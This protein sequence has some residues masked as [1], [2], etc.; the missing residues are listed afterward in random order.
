MMKLHKNCEGC[1]Y[2][3]KTCLIK[4]RDELIFKCPCGTCL[5]KMVCKTMCKERKELYLT[6]INIVHSRKGIG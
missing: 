5:I 2:C 4:F 6:A 3:T 1:N